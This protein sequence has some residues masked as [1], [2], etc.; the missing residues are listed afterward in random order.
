MVMQAQPACKAISH[1]VCAF[2]GTLDIR[3]CIIMC[4]LDI[5]CAYTKE[6]WI[7]D[8]TKT[9]WPPHRLKLLLLGL[10]KCSAKWKLDTPLG[11]H[12]Q[13]QPDI[14][15]VQHSMIVIRSY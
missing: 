4:I 14:T 5:T 9:K 3:G 6:H 2:Q 11:K 1:S 8:D 15:P 13:T 10:I 12:S 7:S